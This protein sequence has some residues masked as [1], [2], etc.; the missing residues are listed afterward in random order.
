MS[1]DATYSCIFC[2][3]GIFKMSTRVSCATRSFHA[4][5]LS[6]KTLRAKDSDSRSSYIP[7]SQLVTPRLSPV[8]EAAEEWFLFML[9]GVLSQ[10]FPHYN[11]YRQFICQS[12]VNIKKC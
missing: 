4:L 5:R 9:F 10:Q 6:N 12:F 2:I 11:L 1:T 8:L 3:F 7:G